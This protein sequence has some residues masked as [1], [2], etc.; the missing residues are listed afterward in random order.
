[1]IWNRSLPIGVGIW[2][3]VGGNGLQQRNSGDGRLDHPIGWRGGLGDRGACRPGPQPGGYVAQ[4]DSAS[5]AGDRDE[6]HRAHKQGVDLVSTICQTD[7]DR[8]PEIDRCGAAVQWA[9]ADAC[10]DSGDGQGGHD[11]HTRACPAG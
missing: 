8:G 4:H 3:A 6:R 9:S 5:P 1:M 7:K 2:R 11:G 10:D